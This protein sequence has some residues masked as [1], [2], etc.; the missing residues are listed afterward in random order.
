M[1]SRLYDAQLHHMNVFSKTTSQM[2]TEKDH[3]DI[4]NECT[5]KGDILE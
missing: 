4:V 2:V 5:L 3:E 1:V